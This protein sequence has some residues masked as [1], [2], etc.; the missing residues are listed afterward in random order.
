MKSTIEI[1]KTGITD[2][3]SDAIV[4]AANSQLLEGGG[5]CGAIFSEAGSYELTEACNEIGECPTGSA[6]I[7]PGFDLKAKY[8]IHAVSPL[9]LGGGKG[10]EE[11]L[12]SC[13]RKGLQLAKEHGIKSI[14][15]PLISTGSFGYPKE[16]GLRIAVDEINAFLL[17]HEM[18][19]YLVVF[20]DKATSLGSRIYPDLEEYIDRHYVEGRLE[21]EYEYDSF[22]PSVGSGDLFTGN[23][24]DAR[25]AE[26][27]RQRAIEERRA[28]EKASEAPAMES[29]PVPV[30]PPKKKTAKSVWG[31]SIFKK[32][33]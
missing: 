29:A 22:P 32:E 28:F 26:M 13:Y 30:V 20:S 21:E 1:R 27:R 6:V 2:L 7:T 16:E 5:V 33:R 25:R 14:A 4:N 18:M 12:R 23:I 11:K 17:S 19:I 15:F 8:I 10:E 9:Y 31:D 24:P 3:N